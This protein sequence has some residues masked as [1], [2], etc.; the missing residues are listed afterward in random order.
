MKTFYSK[1]D[2]KLWAAFAVVP[3]LLLLLAANEKDASASC[4]M[5][6]LAPACVG[7]YFLAVIPARYVFAEDRLV[8]RMGMFVKMEIFYADISGVEEARM[9]IFDKAP[10]LSTDCVRIFL[11]KEKY[12]A[13][14][15]LA[16][17]GLGKMRDYTYLSP[18]AKREFIEELK[19]RAGR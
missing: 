14:W 9:P 8:V 18:S 10:C 5:A 15:V 7:I 6:A 16:K 2:L 19:T 12:Y 4:L 17:N 1:I 3:A 11:P 13:T